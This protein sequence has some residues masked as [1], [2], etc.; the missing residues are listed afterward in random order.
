MHK[1]RRIEE[2]LEKI[3]ER[4]ANAEA[5]LARGE[6]VEGT[7]FLH[8]DDWRGKSGHPKW[9]EN[10]MIPA[11]KRGRARKEKALER[12]VNQEREKRI[13]GR[14]GRRDDLRKDDVS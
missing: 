2:Q 10:F 1:R 13:A 6:N 12:I 7:A 8:F 3:D 5:Y 4:L 11:T 14:R 9:M